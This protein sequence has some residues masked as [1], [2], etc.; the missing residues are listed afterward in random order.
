MFYLIM[1]LLSNQ[2]NMSKKIRL[3]TLTLALCVGV[4]FSLK[5]IVL[6]SRTINNPQ[7][8]FTPFSGG[9]N[10]TYGA[11][12]REVFEGKLFSGDAYSYETRNKLPIHNWLP[13]LSLGLIAKVFNSVELVFILSDFFFPAILFILFVKFV[14]QLTQR[15]WVSV[16]T[17]LSTLF[18][19][20]LISKIPPVTKELAYKFW[21][22][23]TLK[24]PSSSYFSRLPPPQ[25]TFTIF[26]LFIISLYYTL[27][28]KNKNKII[29]LLPGVL[30]GLLAYI[31]FYHWTASLVM[32]VVCLGFNLLAKNKIVAKRLL[33]TLLIA[34]IISSGYFYQIFS[35][36]LIDKQ[37][38][39]GRIDGHFIEP[40][41]TL[42]YGL[43][44]IIIFWLVRKQALKQLLAS[45]FISAV[46]LVNLQA[47]IGYT[48]S[49]GHWPNSTF[50][51]LVVVS[52]GILLVEICNR[53]NRQKILNYFWILLFPIFLY[54]ILNQLGSA[55]SE[56]SLYYLS[57]GEKRLYDWLNKNSPSDNVVL[58]FN[59]TISRRLPA[60]TH[61]Y[62]YLP[63]GC[64]SQLSTEQI[65]ER[66]NLASSIIQLK[67]EYI[68]WFLDN[69]PLVRHM[70]VDF[71]NYSW[72]SDLTGLDFPAKEREII[73]QTNPF[74]T[75]GHLYVP[76]NI[77]Q[78]NLNKIAEYTNLPIAERICRYRL[79][80]LVLKD[81]EK[82][83]LTHLLDSNIFQ[84]VFQQENISLYQIN[85]TLCPQ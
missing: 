61:Q 15:Y 18:L 9:D 64:L 11:Q 4:V 62:P 31:Y 67:P 24:Q 20:Q 49:P 1:P 42:R 63:Y 60:I 85:P 14:Y 46:I 66:F 69:G 35:V 28:K 70:F 54:A 74:F 71:Y 43:L 57:P 51:P 13:I 25:F 73:S 77:K 65:W 80:Y 81:S 39:M 79:D 50:E 22:T 41:T 7:L 29:F 23:I 3:I 40:L 21:Q 47:I 75:F 12:I 78:A 82:L 76:D 59:K 83:A 68:R 53:L 6:Y 27:T 48:V 16:V 17:S 34:L 19:F 2:L 55:K 33:I 56:S 38:Q 45:I 8:F 30:S 32:I 84:L 58:S 37:Y 26:F 72:S 52:A 5:N 36:N 44:S 10:D